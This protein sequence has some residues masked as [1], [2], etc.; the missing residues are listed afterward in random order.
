[1]SN[2]KYTGLVILKMAGQE[3]SMDATIDVVTKVIE[4]KGGKLEQIDRVG[5]KEFVY[6]TPTHLKAGFYV[7][8]HF[9]ADPAAIDKM[10]AELKLNHDV[11]LQ[12]FR[13]SA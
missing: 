2:R 11:H 6:E 12:H 13:R 9:E 10:D 3:D 7:Q 1:M 8:Y 5:R 4:D